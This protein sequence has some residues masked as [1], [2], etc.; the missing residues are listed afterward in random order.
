[1]AVPRDLPTHLAT[2]SQFAKTLG[3]TQQR[4][5]TAIKEGKIGAS[6]LEIFKGNT[7]I[8]VAE[9]RRQ[10]A[11]N[12]TNKGNSSAV[13]A[14]NLEPSSLDDDEDEANGDPAEMRAR[15]L[16]ILAKTARDEQAIHDA[17]LK[18]LKADEME[19]LLVS[20]AD[21]N[22]A[23]FELGREFRDRI[24]GLPSRYTALIRS[25]KSDHAATL[26]LEKALQEVLDE[27]SNLPN[28]LENRGI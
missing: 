25:A 11:L 20:R 10:W 9:A 19:G 6:A 21:V 18:R 24:M 15:K 27:L 7:Y 4:V 14:A 12:Y 17:R 28:R 16:A 2:Q 26:I 8:N 5:S 1:M 23:L 22:A 3:I 13:L